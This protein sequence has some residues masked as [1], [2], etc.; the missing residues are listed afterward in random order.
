MAC[1][2]FASRTRGIALLL[3]F[4]YFSTRPLIFVS[5]LE[6]KRVLVTGANKGIG[7][8][9]CQRLLEQHDNVHVLLGS[10]DA[11]R[12]QQ[13]VE[14]ILAAVGPKC[15]D[16]LEMIVLDTSSDDSVQQAAAATQ[17]QGPLYGI[18]NNA[19]IIRAPTL[20]QV[21]NVNYFG[22]KRVVQAFR[23][24][25]VVPG[26]RIVNIASA[27]GPFFLQELRDKAV[28]NKLAQPWTTNFDELDQLA[29]TT[30]SAAQADPYGFSK[31]LVNAWTLLLARNEPDLIINSVTPGK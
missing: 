29:Q 23:S 26:G 3:L 6:M 14:D 2:P 4:C 24:Q 16:R 10:R 18:I 21:V 30:F 27:S 7:K 20:A 31:A 9:I 28:Y 5:S 22:P 13:A 12:G 19:G 15:K 17:G 25:L 11:A 1:R 8:A